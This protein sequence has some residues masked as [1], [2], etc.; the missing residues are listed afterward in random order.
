MEDTQSMM[1]AGAAE[2][3]TLRERRGSR[4]GFEI[5]LNPEPSQ[6]PVNNR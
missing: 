5:D 3:L 6:R 2:T 4:V 1:S